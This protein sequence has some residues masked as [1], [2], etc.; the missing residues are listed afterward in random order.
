MSIYWVLDEE[1][2]KTV[3]FLPFF[4]PKKIRLLNDIV[5]VSGN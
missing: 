3:S 1:H 5:L 4:S 2:A